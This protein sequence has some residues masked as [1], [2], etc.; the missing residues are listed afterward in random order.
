MSKF[1]SHDLAVL[2]FK[3]GYHEPCECSYVDGVFGRDGHLVDFN[4]ANDINYVS[5][6]T[7]DDAQ[8]WLREKKC[9]S[10]DLY[11]VWS[12]SKEHFGYAI[13]LITP[14]MK[15]RHRWLRKEDKQLVELPFEKAMD[16]GITTALELL[17]QEK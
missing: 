9:I 2:L 11:G 15:V 8:R 14:M 1:V 16:Y 7:L 5:A 12:H 10:V 13:F 4:A 17:K 3:A 6:P